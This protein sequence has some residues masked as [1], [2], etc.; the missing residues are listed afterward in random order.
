MKKQKVISFH[1]SG[2]KE[3]EKVWNEK[4]RQAFQQMEDDHPF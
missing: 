2:A 3:Q 1:N 4:E